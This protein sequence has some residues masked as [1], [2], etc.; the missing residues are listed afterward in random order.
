MRSVSVALALGD[1]P[2][3]LTYFQIV[4]SF[5]IRNGQDNRCRMDIS[6]D[7]RYF[8]AGNS[9]GAV[10]IFSLEIGALVVELSHKRS[11][12]A[13]RCC[14]FSLD[15]RN[16]LFAGEGAFIWRFDYPMATQ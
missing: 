13:V 16:V 12:K 10:S 2:L 1:H 5:Q 6:D 9:N 3:T 8:C 4:R 15:A 11:T 14:A 7:G